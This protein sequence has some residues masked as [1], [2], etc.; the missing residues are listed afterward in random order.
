MEELYSVEKGRRHYFHRKI[1]RFYFCYFLL[2]L[3]FVIWISELTFVVEQH[4][5]EMV[6]QIGR[7]WRQQKP[8]LQCSSWSP[9]SSAGWQSRRRSPACSQQGQRGWSNRRTRSTGLSH[10][11]GPEIKQPVSFYLRLL[12]NTKSKTRHNIS[13]IDVHNVSNE[14]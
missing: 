11:Q 13:F 9:S 12:K 2:Q 8:C 10:S 1:K 7:L 4:G 6:W 5:T 3:N 14:R